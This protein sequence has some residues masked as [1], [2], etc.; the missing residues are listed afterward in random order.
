VATQR[1]SSS[2]TSSPKD[3]VFPPGF[4]RDTKALLMLREYGVITRA[5]L[6]AN[7]HRFGLELYPDPEYNVPSLRLVKDE[8]PEELNEE[9]ETTEEEV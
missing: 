8:E 4:E 2:S 3:S 1:K 6:R 7:I 9:I 5:E